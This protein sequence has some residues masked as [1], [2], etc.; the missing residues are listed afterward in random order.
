MAAGKPIE[1][2]NISGYANVVDVW[3]PG[4]TGTTQEMKPLWLRQ[5][6]LSL[7]I[8]SIRRQM[9]EQES[10]KLKNTVGNIFPN[11]Y[12]IIIQSA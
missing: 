12:W 7:M 3:N 8:Q 11:M 4:F 10:S 9:G 5:L 2:S 1:A 6:P